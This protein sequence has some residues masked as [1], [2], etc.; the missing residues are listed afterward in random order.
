MGTHTTAAACD[1]WDAGECEGTAHCPPRCPRFV[2]DEGRPWTVR[3]AEPTD[4]DRILEMYEAFGTADRT[5][6]IPP[7]SR[8]RRV[9]WIETLLTDGTNVVAEH[10]DEIR[11]HAVYTPTAADRPEVALFVHPEARG[12]GVGTELCRQLIAD[13][14]AGGR[15]AL[16]LHVESGN[17]IARSVYHEVGFQAVERHGDLRMVVPLDGSVA[18]AVRWPPI[19]REGP[20]DPGT[21]VADSGAR[22]RQDADG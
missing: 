4:A 1:G 15:E 11:G 18:T 12:R 21:T 7:A 14:A 20:V 16:V 22:R 8:A 6:G 13:A 2:D 5:R 19:V 3:F 9:E 10:D 17:H